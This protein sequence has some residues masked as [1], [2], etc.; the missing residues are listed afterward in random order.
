MTFFEGITLAVQFMAAHGN[1]NQFFNDKIQDQLDYRAAAD[2]RHAKEK[3]DFV[4]RMKA[5]RAAKVAHS[6]QAVTA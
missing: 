3:A 4:V 1:F 6:D 2:E 5:A